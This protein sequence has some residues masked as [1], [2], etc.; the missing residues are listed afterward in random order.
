MEINSEDHEDQFLRKPFVG[1]T[2]ATLK[3]RF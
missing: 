1:A 2:Q 3:S